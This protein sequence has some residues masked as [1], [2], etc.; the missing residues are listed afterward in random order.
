MFFRSCFTVCQPVE[1][2]NVKIPVP[3]FFQHALKD[4]GEKRQGVSDAKSQQG[5][6]SLWFDWTGVGVVLWPVQCSL[7]RG[8]GGGSAG[9]VL[10]AGAMSAGTSGS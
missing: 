5:K 8:C 3:D 9:G 2:E 1:E 4:R 7:H 6:V 10:A